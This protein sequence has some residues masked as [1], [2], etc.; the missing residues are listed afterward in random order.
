[1]TNEELIRRGPATPLPWF[2]SVGEAELGTN[3]SGYA[4]HAYWHCITRQEG[5]P[6][7][8]IVY[9]DQAV[10]DEPPGEQDIAYLVA[11]AN[12]APKLLAERDEMVEYANLEAERMDQ[13]NIGCDIAARMLREI[14]E[15]GSHE[16]VFGGAE[17]EAAAQ[18]ILKLRAERDALLLRIERDRQAYDTQLAG[19]ERLAELN[20][21]LKQKTREAEA[22][23]DRLLRELSAIDRSAGCEYS[24]EPAA[25]VVAGL[26]RRAETAEAERDKLRK[27]LTALKEGRS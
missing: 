27:E 23:R 15:S 18:A 1:M 17:M 6:A 25:S 4:A 12:A 11:A 16:G 24:S 13:Q 2:A 8:A 22:E 20:H 7:D 21:E 10:D 5:E 26:R 9:G 19:M 3:G 14:A